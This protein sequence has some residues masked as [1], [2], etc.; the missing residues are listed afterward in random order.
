[1]DFNIFSQEYQ[2]QNMF[3]IR[4]VPSSKRI[5]IGRK[6]SMNNYHKSKNRNEGELKAKILRNL[7]K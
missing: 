6:Q 2:Q 3:P 5:R 4:N 7:L 1:M